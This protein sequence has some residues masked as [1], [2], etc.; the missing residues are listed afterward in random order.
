M[1]RITRILSALLAAVMLLPAQALAAEAAPEAAGFAVT[2]AAEQ[3]AVDVYY[4]RDYTAAS[5]ENVSAA[6]ARSSGTGMID[7]SGDGQVNFRV[8]PEDGYEIVSVTADRNYKNLKGDGDTG[9]EGIYRLT[10]VKGPVTVTITTQP[11]VVNRTPLMPL[12][13]VPGS[14]LSP[15]SPFAPGS[16]LSPF[17]PGAPCW[18]RGAINS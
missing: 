7:A 10:K 18:P 11:S 13:A 2:F 16:P 17:V 12:P 3:A 8:R 4:T 5:E 6:V 9:V 1:K 15:L 14:P